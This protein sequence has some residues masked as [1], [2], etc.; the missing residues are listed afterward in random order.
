M[1]QR[2]RALPEALPELVAA[3]SRLAGWASCTISCTAGRC[4]LSSASMQSARDTRLLC[5]EGQVQ[6]AGSA[7][8]S[9]FALLASDSA[10]CASSQKRQPGDT[11]VLSFALLAG[12]SAS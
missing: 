6:L 7:S 11:T 9:S 10:S 2:V 4:V 1:A 12:G 3:S 8:A 5:P